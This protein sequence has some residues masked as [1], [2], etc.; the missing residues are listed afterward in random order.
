MKLKWNY[1]DLH[2]FFIKKLTDK[3]SVKLRREVI[4][5]PALTYLSEI[6]VPLDSVIKTFK[7]PLCTT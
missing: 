3:T 2:N 7:H 5:S 4:D 1:P 6:M